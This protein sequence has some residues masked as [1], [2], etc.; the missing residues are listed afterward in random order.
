[1]K[2]IQM[3]AAAVTTAAMT[4]VTMTAVMMTVNAA[5]ILILRDAADVTEDNEYPLFLIL[6]GREGIFLQ[7]NL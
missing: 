5:L 7:K 2:M 3:T 4:A 1:M 6:K